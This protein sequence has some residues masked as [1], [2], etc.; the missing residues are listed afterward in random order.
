MASALSVSTVIELDR[1][2]R[3]RITVFFRAI[4]AIPAVILLAMLT[5][6]NGGSDSERMPRTYTDSGH[7]HT[8]W[9][10]GGPAVP[11]LA[12][13]ALLVVMHS[14]P[15]WLLTFVHAVQSF[16][17]RL[18]AY[19]LLLR[20][21]YPNVFERPYAYVAYPDIAEGKAL[22]RYMPLVKW[23][24]AIPHYVVLVLVAPIV[25]GI[26]VIA[27]FAII[28]TGRY[29][30]PLAGTVVWYVTYG[31]RVYGYAFALVSDEYPSLA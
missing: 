1:G 16:S 9:S 20:D 27:W 6:A 7:W 17:T 14:Y 8:D 15:N 26:T 12:V 30:E 19:A 10:S 4:L 23:F 21:E 3:N 25:L 29:P 13:A 22:K 24:L 28:F 31:N 5:G 18:A 11:V 2:P